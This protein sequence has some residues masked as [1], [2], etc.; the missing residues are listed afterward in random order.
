MNDWYISAERPDD[1]SSNCSNNTPVSFRNLCAGSA[2]R[3]TSGHFLSTH[4]CTIWHYVAPNQIIYLF[5][6]ETLTAKAGTGHLGHL[7]WSEPLIWQCPMI[8][9]ITHPTSHPSCKTSVH[10]YHSSETA[11]RG[12]TVSSAFRVIFCMTLH[13]LAPS[14]SRVK[15]SFE[16]FHRKAFKLPRSPSFYPHTSSPFRIFLRI[17]QQIPA[18]FARVS[19]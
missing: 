14:M 6:S 19:C 2:M 10:S 16:T 11:K 12:N 4:I 8:Y 15:V 5:K 7:I 1:D 13:C 3:L 9:K 17:L 18:S